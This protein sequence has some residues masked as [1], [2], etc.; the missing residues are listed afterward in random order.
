MNLF[1]GKFLQDKTWTTDGTDLTD[2][3][4]FFLFYPYNVVKIGQINSQ[5]F[6]TRFHF[7]R[8][9]TKKPQNL[10]DFEAFFPN[11]ETRTSNIY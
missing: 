1:A 7:F 10:V 5:F 3:H 2:L 9:Y 8:E 6:K 11:I 4:S